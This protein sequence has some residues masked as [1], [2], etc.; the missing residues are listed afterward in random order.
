MAKKKVAENV[1]CVNRKARFDY[2]IEE[3][4]EAG[5]VLVGSEVKSLRE[6]KAHLKDS[7]GRIGKGEAFLLKAYIS[8]YPAASGLN[9]EPERTRKLLLHQREIQRLTGKVKERGLTLVP[10]KLYFKNG[11]AKV[12]LA[13]ARGKKM[14]DKRDTIRRKETRREVE[15]S[16]KR[17]NR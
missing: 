13:L 14:Y 5:L 9:H 3:T 2:F 16:L 6:G 1:I 10:L 4:F 7:F 11:R 12:E 8:P 17:D 15:R